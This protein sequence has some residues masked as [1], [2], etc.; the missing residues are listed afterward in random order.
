MLKK[1]EDE[2][3]K[4]LDLRRQLEH[5]QQ[6]S[7]EAI[8]RLGTLEGELTSERVAHASTKTKLVAKT[9][10][11][12]THTFAIEGLV[13]DLANEQTARESMKAHL[14]KRKRK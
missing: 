6:S 9:E 3:T 4:S 14:H 5:A 13:V 1:L 12:A 10:A 2:E 11:N 8:S 7:A